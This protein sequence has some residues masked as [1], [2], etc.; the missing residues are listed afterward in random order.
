MAPAVFSIFS[1]ESFSKLSEEITSSSPLIGALGR[2]SFRS[3]MNSFHSVDPLSAASSMNMRPAVSSTTAL[4]VNHQCMFIVPPVPCRQ[5]CRPGGNPTLQWRIASVL[6][7]PEG[8][9]RRYHGRLYRSLPALLNVV[10]PSSNFLRRSSIRAF[11]AGS[12]A[13]RP[14]PAL[15]ISEANGPILALSLNLRNRTY[16]MTSRK[17]T[18]IPMARIF[19]NGFWR[20]KNA[21][22]TETTPAARHRRRRRTGWAWEGLRMQRA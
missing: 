9:T 19:Q 18:M 5:S 20:S 13:P 12:T 3:F 1:D 14:L 16:R 2:Q 15:A 21:M 22:P 4:L 10:T 7:E 11:C 6:P 8:P 17:T